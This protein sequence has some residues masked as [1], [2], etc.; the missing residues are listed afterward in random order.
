M[1]FREKIQKKDLFF[2]FAVI[3][4]SL[5]LV[6]VPTGFARPQEQ[7][8]RA[9]ALVTEVDDSDVQNFTIVKQGDQQVLLEILNGKFEG[10][11]V[12]AANFL[13]G[14]LELDTIYTEGDKAL[15]TLQL[16]ESGETI[17]HANVVDHYR[18]NIEL[19]LLALFVFLLLVYA[20]WTGVK[21]VFSFGFTALLIWKVL[22]PG[23]L[24]NVNP[25]FLSLGIVLALTGVI[26]FLVGGISRKGLVAFFGAAAGVVVTM[27]LSLLF[28]RLFRV[29]GAVKQFSE[30]LL[31]SGF[32][33]LNLTQIF[34]SGIFLASSGAVMDI[35]MDVSASMTEVAE[36]HP[37]IGPAE[38]IRSGFT[39]GR[40]V[41]GTMTTTLLLAYS[42]GYS[43]LLMVFMAQGTPTVNI[44]NITYV[45]AEIL[46]T[47]VGSFGLVTVAPFT[48]AIGGLLLAKRG[49]VPGRVR[50]DMRRE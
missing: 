33:N 27:L 50:A 7:T 15:V 49:V 41:V 25:V 1:I 11:I 13:L 44:F 46:H 32:A 9:K 24:R 14:K 5:V 45:S 10:E 2:L 4:A 19:I 3:A 16:D 21:A 17:L 30:T 34:L 18:I 26:V 42:G 6:F 39:V 36:K 20:G 35:A 29:H 12:K 43:A 31:Y 40:A 38:L 48:A 47:L 22:L 28:G 8:V 23:F 37:E